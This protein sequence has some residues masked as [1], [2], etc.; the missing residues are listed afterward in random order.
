MKTVYCTYCS[1]QKSEEEGEIPAIQRYLS[2]RIAQ[3]NLMAMMDGVPFFILS[4]EYGFIPSDF[5]LP[6]YDHLLQPAEVSIMAA[7]AAEQMKNIGIEQVNYYSNNVEQ[8]STLAPY[9]AVIEKTCQTAGVQL[10]ILY[11]PDKVED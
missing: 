6:Y 2:Q 10:K 11:F 5:P 4:G 1:K 7:R 9:R 3:V 8:D